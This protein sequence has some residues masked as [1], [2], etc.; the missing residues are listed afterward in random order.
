MWES[1]NIVGAVAVF[2]DL[3][4]PISS[5]TNKRKH[6]L[7]HQKQSLSLVVCGAK[8]WII[9]SSATAARY[10]R[11]SVAFAVLL[12]HLPHK[13]TGEQN[14]SPSKWLSIRDAM[15]V[16]ARHKGVVSSKK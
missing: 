5:S 1:R 16:K 4:N 2:D 9:V 8:V 10:S 7:R 11:L 6:D 13:E 12:K 3:R 15:H 14:Y